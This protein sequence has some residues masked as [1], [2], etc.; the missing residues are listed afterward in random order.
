[1]TKKIQIA[2]LGS[3]KSICSKK[4]YQMAE[5]VGEELAKKSCTVVTGGGKGVMEAAFKGAKKAGGL[6]VGILPWETTNLVNKYADVVI[7]TG[8]GWSRNSINLNTSDGAIVIEGGAGTLNELT[9]AYILN[10][11]LVA[12]TP[13]GGIAEYMT[14]KYL[15]KRKTQKINGAK[16]PEEAVKKILKL[17]KEHKK[18]KHGLSKL[19]QELMDLKNDA[20]Q[21]ITR[22]RKK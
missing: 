3:S 15:D 14:N 2:V 6:T 21:Y 11:P 13:S 4:A 17:V 8:I 1:M 16:T 19:D 12:L 20:S 5:K 22:K 7:A 18:K 10:K 9:Y